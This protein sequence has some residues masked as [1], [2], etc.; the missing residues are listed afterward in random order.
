MVLTYTTIVLCVYACVQGSQFSRHDSVVCG[1]HAIFMYL[2]YTQGFCNR[3]YYYGFKIRDVPYRETS[4][5]LYCIAGSYSLLMDFNLMKRFVTLWS[6][7]TAY[8]Y[9]EI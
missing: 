1:V 6:S 4:K 9:F 3:F 5:I 7:Y 8:N 2:Q